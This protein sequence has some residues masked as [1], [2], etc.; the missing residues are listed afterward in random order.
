MKKE[1]IAPETLQVKVDLQQM[2][3]GSP[4]DTFSNGVDSQDITISGSDPAPSEFT[5]RR[6]R[7]QWE[8]DE[9]DY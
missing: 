4:T 9:Y 6:G 5:S 3:A 1:Y 8:D 7:N 2:M